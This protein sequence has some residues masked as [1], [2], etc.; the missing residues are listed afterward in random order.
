ML[1]RWGVGSGK[2]G[3]VARRV[4]LALMILPA[5]AAAE[6]ALAVNPLRAEQVVSFYTARGFSAE[7]IAP[8][9]G[10]CVVSFTF[11]NESESALRFRLA[12]WAASDGTR[13]TPL[14]EWES[15]WRRRGVAEAARIGF[16][17]AQFPPEQEF[18]P[19]DWIMGMAALERRPAG[20]FR[21]LGRYSDDKG[22]HEFTSPELACA[23]D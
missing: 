10:A 13:F 12:D 16:R 6:P 8:Y 17:W 22:Q 19:G 5:G 21:I 2:R 4:A 15:Q 9:A 18:A 14:E 11:R 23:G 1:E 3:L 7:A 20:S